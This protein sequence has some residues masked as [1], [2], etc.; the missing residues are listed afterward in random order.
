MPLVTAAAGV[1]GLAVVAAVDPATGGSYL[2][3]AFHAMT[4]W[5][6]PG[7]GATR[8]THRLLHGDVA[9]ALGANLFLPVFAALLVLGWLTWFLPTVGRRPPQLLARAPLWSW[10]LLGA[11]LLGYGVL[12]NAPWAFAEA[13]AP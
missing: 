11:S 1:G 5:W 6:C 3:C 13:L 9:G 10:V 12:R 7:C 4:G 2:R 8:A